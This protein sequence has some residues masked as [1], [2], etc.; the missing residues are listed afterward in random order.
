MRGRLAQRNG[1][2]HFEVSET[3]QRFEVHGPPG[4]AARAAGNQ[5]LEVTAALAKPRSPDRIILQQFKP[6]AAVAEESASRPS[7]APAT[8]EL[9][10]TGMT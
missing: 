2:F 6:A 3:G 9:V 7:V 5:L 1:K 10:I 8:A 4:G